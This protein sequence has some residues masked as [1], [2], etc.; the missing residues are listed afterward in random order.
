MNPTVN[1]V[2]MTLLVGWACLALVVF[3]QEMFSTS[4]ITSSLTS[5]EEHVQSDIAESTPSTD[6][7]SRRRLTTSSS[8]RVHPFLSNQCYDIIQYFQTSGAKQPLTHNQ[9]YV[10]LPVHNPEQAMLIESVSH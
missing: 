4:G 9:A 6:S 5:A 8:E 1:V 3:R 2:F 10:I 7:N